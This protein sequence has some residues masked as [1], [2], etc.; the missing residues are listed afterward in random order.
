[1]KI[2]ELECYADLLV[3]QAARERGGPAPLQSGVLASLNA[4]LAVAHER[5]L[6]IDTLGDLL[7]MI[8]YPEEGY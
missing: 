8:S 1:M 2:V 7:S 4:V 3:D 6:P 5:G